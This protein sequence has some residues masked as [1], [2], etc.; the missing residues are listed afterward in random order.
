MTTELAKKIS[1]DTPITRR[2]R[3]YTLQFKHLGRV[4]YAEG[5]VKSLTFWFDGPLKDAVARVRRHCEIMDYKYIDCFP[6]IV[7]LESREDLKQ[8]HQD[9]ND[10][11]EE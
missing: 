7:D 1:L 3:A 5:R 2:T 4:G 8:K 10:F 11:T 9:F 6:A